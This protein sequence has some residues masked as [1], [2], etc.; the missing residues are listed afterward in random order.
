MLF[1]SKDG[2]WLD[3][4]T[5]NH[6]WIG[7]IIARCFIDTSSDL[8]FMDHYKSI[9][10]EKQT[11][12]DEWHTKSRCYNSA[13][14]ITRPF[15]VRRNQSQCVSFIKNENLL[16]LTSHSQLHFFRTGRLFCRHDNGDGN[17][18]YHC[19]NWLLLCSFD[20]CLGEGF[21][22]IGIWIAI[23]AF[24]RMVVHKREMTFETA[25]VG[26]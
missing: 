9:K 17:H 6:W 19:D 18:R 14:N 8:E 12:Q 1:W 3:Y 16:L 23:G 22:G 21:V 24:R 15:L 26:R 10:Q 13:T 4:T 2:Q 7:E 20:I 25:H 11:V 5:F